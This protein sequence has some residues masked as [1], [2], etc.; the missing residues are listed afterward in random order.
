M[1]RKKS[2]I[3]VEER[4]LFIL[5]L[6]S[7]GIKGTS[8]IFRFFSD[9]YPE[10]TKRQFEYD[11]KK[12]KDRIKEYFYEEIDDLRNELSK[13]L[14]E[15][16][17]KNL[18]IQDYREC[19]NIIKTISELTGAD[20]PKQIDHTTKGESLNE[21]NITIKNPSVPVTKEDDIDEEI[22]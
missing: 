7:K 6:L 4:V 8:D 19:R 11:L 15:L 1:G 13:H 3:E 20:A 14:W 18:K 22:G 17:N 9:E 5:D 12:A 2:S 16:Y 21:I 10:L